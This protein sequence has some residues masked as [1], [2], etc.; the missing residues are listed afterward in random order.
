[1]V[2]SNDPEPSLL[3]DGFNVHDIKTR[4]ELSTGGTINLVGLPVYLGPDVVQS[5]LATI[6][7]RVL[8]DMQAKAEAGDPIAIAWIQD[9]PFWVK[10]GDEAK[11]VDHTGE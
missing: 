11:I 8:E 1:M 2:A 4:C 5:V 6:I 10:P 7:T 3:P 9:A